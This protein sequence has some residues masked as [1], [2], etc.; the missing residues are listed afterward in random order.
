METASG[1]DSWA[2]AMDSDA[3]W[4]AWGIQPGIE[5]VK[6]LRWLINTIFPGEARVVKFRVKI[7]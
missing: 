5:N 6:G 1:S 4:Q 3:N 2:Y 7:K